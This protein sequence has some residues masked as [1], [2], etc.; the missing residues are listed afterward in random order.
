MTTRT[1]TA[2]PLS[3]LQLDALGRLGWG[4]VL[5]GFGVTLLAVLILF[6]AFV[7]GL[8]RAF[9][10]RATA[11]VDVAGVSVAG[12]TRAEAEARLRERLPSLAQGTLTLSLEGRETRLAYT[13]LGRDY[14]LAR[15]LDSALAAGHSGSAIERTVD[16]IRSLV[17]GTPVQSVA[18]YDAAATGTLVGAAVEAFTRV[19]VDATAQ[20]GADGRFG[21]SSSTDGRRIELDQAT[22]AVGEALSTTTTGDLTVEVGGV[23]IEPAVTTAEAEAAAARA[24]LM[25]DAPLELAF[26][27]KTFSITDAMLKTWIAFAATSD[28]GYAP[29]IIPDKLKAGLEPLVG[30]IGRP[31]RNARYMFANGRPSAV[32][33][34]V[35]GRGL[36]VAGTTAA[37]GEALAARADGHPSSQV[38]LAVGSTD[39]QLTTAAAQAALPKL[40]KL[41]AWTTYFPV[42]I[43]NFWGKNIAIPTAKI[44]GYT[45]APGEWFDF[46]TV[47]GDPSYAEG[48][49]RGGAILNGHTV[50]T[51]A[52]A[53]GICSCSTTLFNAAARA[54]LEIGDRRNHYYYISR[55][56]VGLDATVVKGGSYQ[57]MSFR[58]D[59]ES[60]ILIHGING[61]GV[62]TFE[63]WGI[64]DGRTVSFSR[65]SISSWVN[66]TD[67]VKEVN[68]LPPGVRRRT[69]SP[70]DGFN[71]VVVRTVR[72]SAG[73]VLHEDTWFSHYA[74]IK[75]VVEVGKAKP[76]PRNNGGGGN[77]GG[78][79]GGG[80]GGGL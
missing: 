70:I 6:A 68:T 1:E 43:K 78:G 65:P 15:M 23:P 37:V 35:T 58:N 14:D 27:E 57:T 29:T 2:N 25:T 21:I 7:V 56:P 61:Y 46:W 44:D 26:E 17:R 10:G 75:G 33:P 42:G 71:A 80:G 18:R 38:Q 60:P 34:G 55:Y 52:M 28:G 32:V 8:A 54:G 64:P 62:V 45:L 50:P 20:L 67:S 4:R 5:F 73:A 77:G 13:D 12:L 79:N 9:D 40:E 11:G 22:A 74:A 16:Q 30:E 39:P 48:Y 47:V 51:G 69:E 72:S 31:A 36:D 63:A 49:G 24:A 76:K 59:T 66:A 3:A 19:P 53:G 41:S